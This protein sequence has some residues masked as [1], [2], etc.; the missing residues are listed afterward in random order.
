[1]TTQPEISALLAR[2]GYEVPLERLAATARHHLAR[3]SHDSSLSRVAV[4]GALAKLDPATSW[5]YYK[6][7]MRPELVP[8][9]RSRTRG[10]TSVP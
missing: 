10:A 5:D 2:L 4:A 1:M 6:E 7:T 3:T 9:N 8:A